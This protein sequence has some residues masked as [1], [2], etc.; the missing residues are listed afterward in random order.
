M[1][2]WNHDRRFNAYSN[3]FK[4]RFGRRIQKLTIDAGFTCPNRDGS[5][6]TGGCSYCD[7]NAFSP[8]YCNSRKSIT[9]QIEEGIEFHQKRYRKAENYLAYFQSYTNTYAPLDVLKQ[10]FSEA[11]ANEKIIG[12]IVGTRP[13][14]IDEEKLD[15][16]A[17]IAQKKYVVIEYGVETCNNHTLKLINRGHD[18]ET[19]VRALE[20]TKKMGLKAGI[21]LIFGL[22]NENKEEWMQWTECLSDLPIHSIK[23]HQLQII[24]N[25]PMVA[26]Y[27][28]HPEN[29]YQFS[30]D[31]Y[32]DFI[33][34][35]LERLNPQF[36]IERLTGEVPPAYLFTKPWN[37]LRN[38]QM[39][40]LIE[41]KM[42]ERNTWQGRLYKR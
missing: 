42:E 16:L 10:K 32:V 37:L 35:F 27:T 7:N 30:F 18:F 25:T 15:Y 14:C 29:F 5:I 17:E 8:S 34:D 1:Y 13:D 4:H 24:K 22:P 36:L 33:I 3:Y 38:D 21:H 12:I 23:F 26:Y 41:N 9:Q 28:Q 19:S 31:D 40:Q 39:L 2:A 11:L 6:A 20:L